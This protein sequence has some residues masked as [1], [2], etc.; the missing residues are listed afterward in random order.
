MVE[1]YRKQRIIHTHAKAPIEL[2]KDDPFVEIIANTSPPKP[3]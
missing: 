3:N 2:E 1:A